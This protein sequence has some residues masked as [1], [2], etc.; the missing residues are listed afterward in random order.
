[1]GNARVSE[2]FAVSERARDLHDR[3]ARFQRES[4][5]PA[6]AEYFAHLEQP[7]QRWTI[8]PVMETLKTQAR[9]AG[10]WNLFLP[11]VKYGASLSNLDYAPLAEIMGRSLIAPEVFN[12]NAP[13]TGN[14]EVLA[15]YGSPVQQQ[16]WLQPL[17]AGEIRS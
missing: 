14:M 17:L 11:G 3:V 6:E 12:C 7:G 15:Q 13:D 16:C 5:E 4:I 9:A 1:M 8:P 10:L 2:L